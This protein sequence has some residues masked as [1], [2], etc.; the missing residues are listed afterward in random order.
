MIRRASS[1]TR[2]VLSAVILAWCL[3]ATSAWAQAPV[4]PGLLDGDPN[5]RVRVIIRLAVAFQPEGVISGADVLRQRAAIAA[6]QSNARALLLGIGG[7]P[8]GFATLPWMAAEITR[9]QIADIL[10]H[11]LVAGVDADPIART[12]LAESVPRVGAPVA[13]TAGYAGTGWT[14]AV[15]DT[16][17][18]ALHPFF[19]GAVV[20]EACFST[21]GSS[22]SSFCP[23]G[24]SSSVGA[25][26]GMPCPAGVAGCAH[27]THVAGIAVGRDP[28]QS[29]YGVARQASLF[30]IQ[31]FSRFEDPGMCAPLSAP[32]ALAYMSDVAR[33]LD[34]VMDQAGPG[35][36]NRVA[37]VNL[38]LSST[39]YAGACDTAPG[40]PPIKAAIDHLRSI[41]IA[42]VIAAGNEGASG[43][44]GAPSC[45]ST[46]VSVGSTEDTEDTLSAFSNHSAQLQLGAPGSL[47]FSALPGGDYG[48]LAG[49]SMAAPHVAGAWAIIKQAQPAASVTLVLDE[50]KSTGAGVAGRA[51]DETFTRIAIDRAMALTPG[52]VPGVPLDVAAAVSGETI[53]VT[54]SAPT[55]GGV[56]GYIVQAGSQAGASDFFD[57]SVGMTNAVAAVVPAGTYFIR[58]R[59]FNAEGIGAASAEVIA[60]VVPQALPG[61]PQNVSA[62]ASGSTITLTWAPP[63]TGGAASGYVV[64]AG[65][66]PGAADFFNGPVGNVLAVAATVPGGTYYIRVLAQNTSGLGLP[67]AET[68]VTVPAGCT[69]PAAPEVTGSATGTLASLAW[70]V[71]A[72]GPV[73]GYILQAGSAPGA[74]DVFA[75]AVGNVNSLSAVVTSGTYYAR[76]I[77]VAACGAGAASAD[78]VIVVP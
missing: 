13:W 36:R 30:P 62:V 64:Q 44:I 53:T 31:V 18:D 4:T 24:V 34:Y 21:T 32:C 1:I 33:A 42:T 59:A 51:S 8:V 52:E 56:S 73:T 46:A 67:S 41:G 54:W 70:T 72:G 43:A 26:A 5:D 78:A 63:V 61:D 35:N 69:T 68:S 17:V 25:G 48:F 19:T 77:A 14:V 6:A 2:C 55:S 27:G 65:S 3:G 22:S 40:M 58:I 39:T 49:T 9:H 76:I 12:S 47:I 45:V 50:L 57:G 75:G 16:G 28:A 71:P 74:S 20:S 10:T 7:T 11:P 66:A 37:A 15:L 23:G 29:L 38:S 60:T